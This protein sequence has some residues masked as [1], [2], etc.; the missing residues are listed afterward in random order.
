MR[1]HGFIKR[2]REQERIMPR[3]A[4]DLEEGFLPFSLYETEHI[5]PE[6]LDEEKR[7]LYAAMIQC[8]IQYPH[9]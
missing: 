6:R 9:I 4:A 2:L 8:V 3:F 1:V 5:P 7:L